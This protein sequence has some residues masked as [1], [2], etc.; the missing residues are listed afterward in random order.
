VTTVGVMAT[1]PVTRPVATHS[2]VDGQLTGLLSP[3]AAP[4]ATAEMQ[5]QDTYD[6][7]VTPPGGA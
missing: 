1:V 4:A 5:N 3:P 2:D 7:D 6:P